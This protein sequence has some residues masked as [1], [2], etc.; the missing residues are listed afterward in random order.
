MAPSDSY[1]RF[2]S[3]S[4]SHG[5]NVDALLVLKKALKIAWIGGQ[6]HRRDP[7]PTAA[8]AT[9]ASMPSSDLP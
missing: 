3:V 1:G 6:H 9:S 4:L 8:A 7:F 5:A 2:T